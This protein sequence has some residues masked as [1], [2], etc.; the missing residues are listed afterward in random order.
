MW[1]RNA[2][3]ENDNL[4]ESKLTTYRN[5]LHTNGEISYLIIVRVNRT[6]F[7]ITPHKRTVTMD[8]NIGLGNVQV[9]AIFPFYHFQMDLKEQSLL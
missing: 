5:N 4:R 3:K 8:R 6:W 9:I 2:F 7:R 1:L